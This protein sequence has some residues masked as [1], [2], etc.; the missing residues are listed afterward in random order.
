[1]SDRKPPWDKKVLDA[2][3][4]GAVTFGWDSGEVVT[5]HAPEGTL[6]TMQSAWPWI[7]ARLK[8]FAEKEGKPRTLCLRLT[9]GE[10]RGLRFPDPCPGPLE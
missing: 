9:S 4:S 8:S 3:E 5:L 2:M 6:D 7:D 10:F 1:M